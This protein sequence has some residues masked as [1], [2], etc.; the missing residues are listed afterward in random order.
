[1]ASA[2]TIETELDDTFRWT[3]LFNQVKKCSLVL[4]AMCRID[5]NLIPK[6]ERLLTELIETM[7]NSQK[8]YVETTS[9]ISAEIRPNSMDVKVYEDLLAHM[10]YDDQTKYDCRYATTSIANPHEQ[11][12][13]LLHL[14]NN[15]NSKAQ[16]EIGCCYYTGT[17]IDE[18]VLIDKKEAAHWFLK[19]SQL[20]DSFAQYNLYVCLM[21]TIGSATCDSNFNDYKKIALQCL[22]L[23]A[24]HNTHHQFI[25]D[26]SG[27]GHLKSLK[28]QR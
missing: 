25:F 7:S 5:Q 17:E 13:F 27:V 10:K 15:G 21:E 11:F 19:A 6:V 28:K 3:N 23:H 18:T 22:A 9:L 1:M 4:D 12:Q 24:L 20:S 2:K 8:N 14:A 16:N 26:G